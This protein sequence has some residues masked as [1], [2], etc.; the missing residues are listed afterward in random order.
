MGKKSLTLIFE[1]R[2][3]VHEALACLLEES[4]LRVTRAV[5]SALAIDDAAVTDA[6]PFTRLLPRV[7]SL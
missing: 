1:S 7:S 3:L 5:G 2:G 4:F 6:A